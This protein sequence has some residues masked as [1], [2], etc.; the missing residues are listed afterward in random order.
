MLKL[1]HLPHLLILLGCLVL[2][3][4]AAA[5]PGDLEYAGCLGDNA[6]QG[7]VDLPG[8]PLTRVQDVAVS[9]DGR[10]VYAVSF[11]R[12]AVLHFFRGPGGELAYDG[13]VSN[14]SAQGC[15]ALTRDALDGPTSVAVSPDNRSVYVTGAENSSVAEFSRA[16]P[17]GQITFVA[18][19]AEKNPADACEDLPESVLV[20]PRSVTVSPDGR[21]VY[22]ASPTSDSVAHFFRSASGGLMLDGCVSDFA[23]V[24]GCTKAPSPMGRPTDVSVSPD[25]RSLY[26]AVQNTGA[27]F[28][29]TRLPQGQI[30]FESCVASEP[31]SGCADAPGNNLRLVEDVVARDSAVYTAGGGGIGRGSVLV[32]DP[33]TGRLTWAGCF[34]SGEESCVAVPRDAF[35]QSGGLSI[36]PDGRSL[37]ITGTD[38]IGHLTTGPFGFGSCLSNT[39]R[40]GCSALPQAPLDDPTATAVSPDGRSVYAVAGNSNTLVRFDREQPAGQ[41]PADPTPT[42]TP[43][44]APT[45]EPP[46]APAAPA[47]PAE[48]SN[49]VCAGK[50]ATVVGTAGGDRLRGTRRA[51]VIAAL[52]GNDRIT[53]LRGNDVVCGGAG[54]DRIDGGAGRDR[55]IGGA[56]RD[57]VGRCEVRRSV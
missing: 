41:P 45:A 17:D 22:V 3:N 10:S 36:S 18:C 44:P 4:A 56:G 53:G 14:D 48:A 55:C 43:A 23:R 47:A 7:C 42:P 50:R 12:D 9:P 31:V 32:R 28:S 40:E 27:V 21:S 11:E 35:G 54:R 6:S 26:V 33:A 38:S 57:R 52:G 25:G 39:A 5:A 51:D 20:S 19:A 13:C 49:P 46:A 8:D 30:V 29:F 16:M 1:K 37:Y 15:T 24:D 2:P 34:R